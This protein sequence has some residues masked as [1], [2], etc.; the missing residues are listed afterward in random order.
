MYWI[1]PMAGAAAAFAPATRR[2]PRPP[3][4]PPPQAGEGISIYPPPLA[5]EG[6]EGD[7]GLAAGGLHLKHCARSRGLRYACPIR[8][9]RPRQSDRFQFHRL[10]FGAEHGGA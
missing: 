5:G 7:T 8:I 3:P 6:R 9:L 2:T 4:C 1:A 10:D